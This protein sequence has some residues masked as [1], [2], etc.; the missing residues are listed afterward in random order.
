[1]SSDIVSYL[2]EEF[3]ENLKLLGSSKF[4]T[5]RCSDDKIPIIILPECT[6]NG[7]S[8]FK[9]KSYL[10]VIFAAEDVDCFSKMINWVKSNSEKTFYPLIHEI[11][12]KT[13]MKIK[14]PTDFS[15]VNVD[16]SH[17]ANGSHWLTRSNG[18]VIRCAVEI[19]CVWENAEN[20][21]ISLQ[22]VQCKVIEEITCKIENID[23]Y[24][25]YIPFH[26]NGAS[27]L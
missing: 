10:H 6:A 12:G 20:V 15:V 25:I 4:R 5:P 16:G 7:L 14:V 17:E 24:P 23:E 19:P 26:A 1:M 13:I 8:N 18:T 27:S 22:L 2:V 9:D 3:P 11:D 21:G